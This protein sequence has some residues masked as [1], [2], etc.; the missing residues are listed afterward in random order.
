[1]LSLIILKA[2]LQSYRTVRMNVQICNQSDSA[3]KLTV[4]DY[5]GR[6]DP[7]NREEGD[8]LLHLSAR[9]V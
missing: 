6:T 7:E 1:M 2:S 3:S 5:R 8:V 9:D 4:E